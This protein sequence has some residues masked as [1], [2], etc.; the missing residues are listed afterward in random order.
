M[1]SLKHLEKL[2][3]SLR[4]LPGVGG[5]SAERF[6]YKILEWPEADQKRFGS[7]IQ[8]LSDHIE[9]CSE[10]GLLY[11]NECSHCLDE[12][13]SKDVLCVVATFKDINAI[14]ETRE[15]K[16]RYHVLGGLLSPLDDRLPEHLTLSQLKKRAETLQVKELILA[17]D[18]TLEGDATSLWIKNELKGLNLKISRP[19]F[20]LPM[21]SQL[22]YVDGGTLARAL[23]SRND[24]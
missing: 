2:I 12:A 10:C 5:R 9:T 1:K 11:E 4:K 22:D 6:A 7:V 17:L 18:S 15:F 14:E 3:D 19:A 24:F 8:E 20:G 23:Q 16:G 21:G 13:R